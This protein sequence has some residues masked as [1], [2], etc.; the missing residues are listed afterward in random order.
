MRLKNSLIFLL[1]LGGLTQAAIAQDTVVN[2]TYHGRLDS[3][4]SAILGQERHMLIMRETGIV[5]PI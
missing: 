5:S 1:I 3:I 4:H 2:V